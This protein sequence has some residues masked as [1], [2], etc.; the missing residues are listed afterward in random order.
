MKKNLQLLISFLAVGGMVLVG[1]L[2]FSDFIDTLVNINEY[3]DQKQGLYTQKSWDDFLRQSLH[4]STL[5]YVQENVVNPSIMHLVDC[6]RRFLSEALI[7][8]HALEIAETKTSA[9]FRL[10]EDKQ[11]IYRLAEKYGYI[12]KAKSFLFCENLRNQVA[13]PEKRTPN[14]IQN[15]LK[16]SHLYTQFVFRFLDKDFVCDYYDKFPVSFPLDELNVQYQAYQKVRQA[17]ILSDELTY[18]LPVDLKHKPCRKKMVFLNKQGI[19][20]PKES[21][22][23]E[24][25]FLNRNDVAHGQMKGGQVSSQSIS[26]I[27][28]IRHALVHR[29]YG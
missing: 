26:D 3:C 6:S 27:S 11:Q 2:Y 19:I 16:I 21:E 24:Q 29:Q 8:E 5:S 15:A 14:I 1:L 9:S 4:D 23:M 17:Q 18:L 12:D 28:A 22:E 25:L 13:H 20:T 10:K 7:A